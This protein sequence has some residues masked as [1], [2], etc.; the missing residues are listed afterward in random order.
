MG[1]VSQGETAHKRSFILV[2][3]INKTLLTSVR[4]KIIAPDFQEKKKT[5]LDR[6]AVAGCSK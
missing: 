5:N 3:K 1:N 4:P 2:F 6:A